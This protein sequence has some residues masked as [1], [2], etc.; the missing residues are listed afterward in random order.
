MSTAVRNLVGR[1]P[2]AVITVL[3]LV[4]AGNWL[5]CC[6]PVDQT[7]PSLSAWWT[8]MCVVSVANIWLWRHSALAVSD[9]RSR[10]D[11][12]LYHY[13]RWQLALSAVYVL[14]CAFRAMVPR[15]DVQR[16]GLFDTWVSS[17]LVGRSVATIAELCFVAQWSLF[18]RRL[19][20]HTG[21]WRATALAR[22]IVPLIVVAEVCSWYAVLTTAYVG[23]AIEDS[24]W[25]L[26]ATLLALGL[27]PVWREAAGTSR[28]SVAVAIAF[29]SAF[30]AY[31]CAKDVPMYVSRWLA[32]QAKGRQYLS[33]F[34]GIADV[35]SRWIVTHSWNAWRP[36]LLW[37]SLYF[38]VGVW[39]SLALV[40]L[41]GQE[42]GGHPCAGDLQQPAQKKRWPTAML[43][44]RFR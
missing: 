37:M 22:M 28:R 12:D 35:G 7:S 9:R 11:P 42:I 44:V 4:V 3:T 6:Q 31:L 18:L 24:I 25:A 2:G 15:A 27:L 39:C 23:N 1:Y 38:S 40:H 5:L 29:A 13:Q 14:G 20:R 8:V 21:C 19:A 41:P 34:H 43:P 10:I 32:D 17:V 16:F 36:E 30:V 26:T 33:I